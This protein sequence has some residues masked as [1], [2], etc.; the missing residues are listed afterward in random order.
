MLRHRLSVIE[1]NMRPQRSIRAKVTCWKSNP[2][3]N[4]VFLVLICGILLYTIDF[5]FRRFLKYN[6]VGAGRWL[7][8]LTVEYLVDFRFDVIWHLTNSPYPVFINCSSDSTR[9]SS[10]LW[11]SPLVLL[12]F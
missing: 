12:R 10:L 1:S 11:L 8:K 2:V 3:H 9:S 6:E 5:M 4:Y 7:G